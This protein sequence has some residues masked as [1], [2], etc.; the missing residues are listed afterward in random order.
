MEAE[1][2]GVG[3]TPRTVRMM[4]PFVA[5]RVRRVRLDRSASPSGAG[6]RG[7]FVS[8]LGSGLAKHRGRGYIVPRMP[9]PVR[10]RSG[11][12]RFTAFSWIVALA[13]IWAPELVADRS[14]APLVTSVSSAAP[15]HHHEARSSS[16][17]G[18]AWIANPDPC[19]HC[20]SGTRCHERAGCTPGGSALLS[21]APSIAFVAEERLRDGWQPDRPLAENP[22]PPT[23]PPPSI[24]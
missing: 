14:H 24:L 7:L 11:F 8:G 4:K 10:C 9:S 1:E 3:C 16:P 15:S 20:A 22:T 5:P 21:A 2:V 19:D 17:T 18:P 6:A 23:P 13:N 12:R